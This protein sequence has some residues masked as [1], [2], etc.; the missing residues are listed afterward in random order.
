MLSVTISLLNC[1]NFSIVCRCGTI[2]KVITAFQPISTA[3]TTSFCELTC[4]KMRLPDMVSAPLH[5]EI[6]SPLLGEISWFCWNWW[7]HLPS[8][9]WGHFFIPNCAIPL[10]VE[11]KNMNKSH[12]S[13][14]LDPGGVDME[15]PSSYAKHLLHL[16]NSSGCYLIYYLS[17]WN[18]KLS[19]DRCRLVMGPL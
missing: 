15:D 12:I 5:E 10:K 9:Q 8:L 16:K 13:F 6:I 7:Q 14:V 17:S 18:R 4:Q 1:F 3:W 11:L 19:L 2:P